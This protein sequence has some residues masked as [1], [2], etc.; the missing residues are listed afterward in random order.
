MII[1][2][3]VCDPAVFSCSGGGHY[4]NSIRW[5]SAS[6]QALVLCEPL[7]G[8]S[9]TGN[10]QFS[11]LCL[12]IILFF[13]NYYSQPLKDLLSDSPCILCHVHNP[14]LLFVFF[15]FFVL[16]GGGLGKGGTVAFV[17]S[18]SVAAE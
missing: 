4:R 15:C 14:E 16:G 7:G 10:I 13:L 11:P 8:R 2:L 3:C 9:S 12:F 5:N 1:I 17:F 6:L 18:A